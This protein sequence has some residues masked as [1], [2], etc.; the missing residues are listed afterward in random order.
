M[1]TLDTD[2]G[3]VVLVTL[4]LDGDTS[5]AAAHD[6]ASVVE[7]KIREALPGVADVVVHTEP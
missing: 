2:D 3:L 7:E 6:E 4:G 5:L 1:R